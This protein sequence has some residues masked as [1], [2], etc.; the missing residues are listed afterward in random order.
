MASSVLSRKYVAQIHRRVRGKSYSPQRLK[1][2]I[3]SRLYGTA[4]AV[5]FPKAALTH[6]AYFRDTIQEPGPDQR[7]FP[8]LGRK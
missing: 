3:F 6:A 1:P 4:E 5:P 2:P 8:L 7:L